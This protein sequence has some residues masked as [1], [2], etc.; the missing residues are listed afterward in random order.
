MTEHK[1]NPNLNKTNWPPA[2]AAESCEED[3]EEDQEDE[4]T[5]SWCQEPRAADL[6]SEG[7]HDYWEKERQRGQGVVREQ[8]V[9]HEDYR[10][11][12]GFFL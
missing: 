5:N 11:R 6:C 3:G 9:S 2:V 7:S 10:K 1:Q 8:E 4:E 12:F